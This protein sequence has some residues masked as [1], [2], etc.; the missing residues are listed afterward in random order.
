MHLVI[1]GGGPAGAVA[2]TTLVGRGHD[3]TLLEASPYPPQKVSE[4][5]S[6]GANEML[7]TLGLLDG[8]KAAGHLP[9][10]GH[11]AF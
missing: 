6:P 7:R 3:V 8:M 9:T 11:R 4:C 10:L 2:A 5:L 1:V